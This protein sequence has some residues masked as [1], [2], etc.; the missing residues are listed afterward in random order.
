MRRL[1]ALEERFRQDYERQSFL[2]TA[3]NILTKLLGLGPKMT[4]TA[5][6]LVR[7]AAKRIW[8]QP[9]PVGAM[10]VKTVLNDLFSAPL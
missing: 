8:G 2:Q 1:H 9:Q 5:S 3:R 10:R 6:A 4:G 7:R